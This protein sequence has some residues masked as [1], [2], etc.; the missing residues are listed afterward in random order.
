MRSENLSIMSVVDERL[1]G[2]MRIIFT[3][4]IAFVFFLFSELITAVASLISGAIDVPNRTAV[5]IACWGIF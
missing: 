4:L 1:S 5:V 3:H 2:R